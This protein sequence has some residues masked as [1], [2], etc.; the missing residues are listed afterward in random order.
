MKLEENGNFSF[1]LKGKT[2]E[3]YFEGNSPKVLL[4]GVL[5]KSLTKLRE[6][7]LSEKLPIKLDRVNKDGHIVVLTTNELGKEFRRYL[8]IETNRVNNIQKNNLTNS[9]LKNDEMIGKIVFSN[10][11][12]IIEEFKHHSKTCKTDINKLIKNVAELISSNDRFSIH[13]SLFTPENKYNSYIKQ[14]IPSKPGVYL[15]YNKIN[16][17]IIYIGMAGKIKTNGELTNHPISKRLQAPRCKD[18]STKKDINS[19]L[20]VKAILDVFKIDEIE[21]IILTCKENEPAAYIESILLY[22]YFKQHNVLPILN[23]AF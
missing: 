7:V 8:G 14:N 9:T 13:K 16:N 5:Q 10:K 6:Y 23:N 20:F 21:F 19:N 4:E 15:W 1:L 11:E 2:Y 17:E 22:N 12:L 3:L 18:I